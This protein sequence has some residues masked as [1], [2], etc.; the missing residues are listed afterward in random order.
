MRDTAIMINS[1]G[2]MIIEMDA[3]DTKMFLVGIATSIIIHCR[4]TSIK[5]KNGVLEHESNLPHYDRLIDTY[6][7]GVRGAVMAN[8]LYQNVSI[9]YSLIKECVDNKS[10]QGLY[11]MTSQTSNSEPMWRILCL[12]L[13]EY[14]NCRKRQFEILN[15]KVPNA[16]LELNSYNEKFEKL[17]KGE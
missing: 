3:I 12:A 16:I 4:E 7:D 9:I 15:E 5:E 13:D 2:K 11:L 6:C 8:S 17:M 14:V 1:N 10:R